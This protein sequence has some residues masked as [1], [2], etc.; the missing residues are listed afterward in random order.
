MS[1]SNDFDEGETT[2]AATTQPVTPSLEPLPHEMATDSIADLEMSAF[3]DHA[4]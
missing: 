4:S 3:D 2:E 1:A